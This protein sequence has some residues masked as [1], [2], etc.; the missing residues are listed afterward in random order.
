VN[1]HT[2]ITLED[3][4]EDGQVRRWA[5]E[6]PPEAALDQ[7][8]IGTDVPKVGDTLEFCAFPSPEI[9]RVEEQ[10]HAA[11]GLILRS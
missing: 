11:T 5:V 1:P 10:E 7:R 2:V 6:G 9:V 3:R 4:S 8:G